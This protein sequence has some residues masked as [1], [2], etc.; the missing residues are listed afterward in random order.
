MGV[1]RVATQTLH[2]RWTSVGTR[3]RAVVD[4]GFRTTDEF[5]KEFRRAAGD[6]DAA[7]VAIVNEKAMRGVS[8]TAFCV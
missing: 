1:V 3:A 8:A 5:W 7:E 4:D 2:A 6:A